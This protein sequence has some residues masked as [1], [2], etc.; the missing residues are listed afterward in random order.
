MSSKL[1]IKITET[2][3]NNVL[4]AIKEN[5]HK[6]IDRKLQVIKLRYEGMK[7]AEI[8]EK[9]DYSEPSIINL[10]KE[11]KNSGIEEYTKLKYKGNHRSLTEEEEDEIL[12]EFEERAEKGQI[13]TVKEIK[14]KFDEKIGKDTGR[15]YIYML[16][17]RKGFRKVMPRNR[18]PKK[19]N[20]EVIEASKKL[21][22][23]PEN[24]C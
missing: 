15:G 6:I 3:Y 16:L 23:T 22:L 21:T 7:N 10:I 24:P 5:K 20:E 8:C 2:E 13:V 4:I 12:K 17:K 18:H 1:K 19:A 9:L 11:F 14:A